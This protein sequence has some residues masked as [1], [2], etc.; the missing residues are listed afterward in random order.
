MDKI[1]I[2]ADLGH[3]KA[4]KVS[5]EPMESARI[6]LIESYDTIEGHGKMGDKVT[7]NAGRFR[8]AE[9][10]K[11]SAKGYGEPHNLETEKEKRLVKLIAK[12]INELIKDEGYN[13][14]GLAAPAGMNKQI[15]E[16]LEPDVKACLGR[17]VTAD[18]TNVDKSEIPG[19]FE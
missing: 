10:I 9:G 3:F 19:H 8:R 14:W 17:S 2:V 5:K 13:S 4:Y 16:N 6:T 12:A 7:D 11:G 15:I 1:L 18:L